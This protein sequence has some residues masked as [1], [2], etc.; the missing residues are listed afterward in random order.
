MLL[1]FCSRWSSGHWVNNLPCTCLYWCCKRKI[2]KHTI[3]HLVPFWI[4]RCQCIHSVTYFMFS[5]CHLYLSFRRQHC[6]NILISA[7]LYTLFIIR[8]SPELRSGKTCSPKHYCLEIQ[9][10]CL[11]CCRWQY[12]DRIPYRWRSFP[13]LG[14]GAAT[15]NLGDGSCINKS[16]RCLL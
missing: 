15:T 3:S 10:R 12:L 14:G 9:W 8:H 11:P 7:H 6:P 13:I 16:E 4:T 2:P 1:N 5:F